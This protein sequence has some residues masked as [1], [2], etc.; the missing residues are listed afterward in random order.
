MTDTVSATA[1]ARRRRTRIV[2]KPART[3]ALAVASLVGL[4]ALGGLGMI[5]V[6]A[7]RNSTEGRNDPTIETPLLLLPDTPAYLVAAIDRTKKP[8]GLFVLA[9]KIDGGGTVIVV[10]TRA[11]VDTRDPLKPTRPIDSYPDG[12][13]GMLTEA[14]GAYLGVGFVDA[15]ALE[16]TALSGFLAPLGPVT[17]NL[18]KAVIDTSAD[19]VD[20]LIFPQGPATLQGA[21]AARF[22]VAREEG[23]TEQD[24]LARLGGFWAAALSPNV[25]RPAPDAAA[26]G[27]TAILNQVLA[28]PATAITLTGPAIVD[29]L[30]NPAKLDMVGV[31]NSLLRQVMA[32]VLPGAVSPSTNG[33]RLEIRDPFNDERVRREVIGRMTY[34][35]AVVMWSH[36]V[37]TEPVVETILEYENPAR[38]AAVDFYA[39]ALGPTLAG[40]IEQA[41]DNVD[42]VITIG[43]ALHDEILKNM[44]TL[45]QPAVSAATVATVP[46]TTKA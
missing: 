42:L 29:P 21:D 30:L 3:A 28:G 39:Q 23:A 43:Q 4:G 8:V 2:T 35:K 41:V 11:R 26:T 27:A 44:G 32:E 14:V 38:R 33:L 36:P 12:D 13:F 22:A 45:A 15:W 1:T 34:L 18:E 20:T 31:D 19:R 37:T 24:R 7:I 6:D 40:E 17:F 9:P 46:T 5:G 10:P 16:E 25:S